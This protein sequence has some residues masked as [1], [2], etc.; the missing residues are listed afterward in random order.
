MDTPLSGAG[1]SIVPGQTPKNVL[2]E[3][4]S[5]SEAGVRLPRRLHPNVQLKNGFGKE[6]KSHVPK[7]KRMCRFI[8]LLGSMPG[9]F[10]TGSSQR[11][12]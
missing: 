4:Q 11:S 8:V 6:E 2:G 9:S 3:G 1:I 10:N 5:W 7:M 12:T